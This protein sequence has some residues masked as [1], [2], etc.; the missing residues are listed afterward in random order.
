MGETNYIFSAALNGF[1]PLAWKEEK[2]ATGS[3]PDDAIE[4][5]YEDYLKFTTDASKGKILGSVD[6]RPAWVDIPPPTHEELIASAEATK[7]RLKAQAGAEIVWRQDAVDA[8]I[9]TDEETTALTEW[10]KYRVLLMRIDTS[11]APDI[12]WPATPE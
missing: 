12:E 2:E 7:L 10:K 1:L 6:G 3:W 9:A 8:G 4:I 5:S 11:K